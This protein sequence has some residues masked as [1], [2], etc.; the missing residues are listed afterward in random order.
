MTGDWDWALAELDGLLASE[1]E[2]EDR[3]PILE[4]A[5]LLRSLRGLPVAAQMREFESLEE[6][7][8]DPNLVQARL[9]LAGWVSLIDGRLADSRASFRAQA[10]V[11]A[12]NAPSAYPFAARA[13]LWAFDVDAAREDLAALDGLGIHGPLVTARRSALT[14]AGSHGSTARSMHRT[15]CPRRRRTPAGDATCSGWCPSS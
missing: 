4:N 3:I 15:S 9:E 14:T 7:A 2:R 5:I 10:A 13:A 6:G 12:L 1:L 8:S 11:S